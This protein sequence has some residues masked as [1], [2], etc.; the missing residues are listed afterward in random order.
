[1]SIS[2]VNNSQASHSPTS[3]GRRLRWAR[4]V[5]K[6]Y[7]IMKQV[8]ASVG[9][10]DLDYTGVEKARYERACALILADKLRNS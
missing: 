5:V 6:R 8:H 1:V 3:G 7:Q 2:I 10:A 4:N 9:A